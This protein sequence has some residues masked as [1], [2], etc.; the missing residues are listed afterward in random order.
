MCSISPIRGPRHKC[1]ECADFDICQDCFRDLNRGEREH[2]AGHVF[3]PVTAVAPNLRGESGRREMEM[4]GMGALM[5][6]G[7]PTQARRADGIGITE[8]QMFLTHME[9]QMVTLLIDQQQR[10]LQSALQASMQERNTILKPAKPEA[11]EKL[12]RRPVTEAECGKDGCCSVCLCE[13]EYDTATESGREVGVEMPCKHIF[14]EDCLVGWLKR[15]N[16]CPVCRHEIE[17]VTPYEEVEEVNDDN[18]V[19]EVGGVGGGGGVGEAGG[20]GRNGGGGR[21]IRRAGGR[22]A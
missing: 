7:G 3:A 21:C 17:G 15:Q 8:L 19:G 1:Q 2:T 6:L 14:H 10:S 11:I 18:R 4:G 9:L 13:W 5:D 16:T 20:D 12:V 22:S